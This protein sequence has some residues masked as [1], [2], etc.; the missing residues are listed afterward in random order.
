MPTVH[1]FDGFRVFIPANDHRPAHVHVAKAGNEAVFVLNCPGGPVSLRESYG[2]KPAQLN[3]IERQLNALTTALCAKW[4]AISM[5]S[6]RAL[7]DANAAGK[8]LLK[9]WPTALTAHYEP[10]IGQIIITL[11]TGLQFLLDPAKTEGLQEASRAALSKIEIVGPGL[12]IY[13]PKLDVDIYIPGLLQG[14]FGSRKWAAAQLGRA[15]GSARTKD[16]SA[17]ARENGKQG[18]RPRKAATR[19]RG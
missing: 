1:A 19:K 18:G 10:K 4:E 2:F 9:Q 12:G 3:A 16:K 13:F 11:N 8:A 6:R 15:G 5:V 7:A 17:A 14:H